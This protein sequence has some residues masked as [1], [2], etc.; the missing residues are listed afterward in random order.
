MKLVSPVYSIK[1]AET[2]ALVSIFNI[3]TGKSVSMVSVSKLFSPVYSMK[4]AETETP[5]SM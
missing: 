1:P 4:P 3:E 5:V 2:E